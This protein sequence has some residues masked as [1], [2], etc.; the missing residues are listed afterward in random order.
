MFANGRRE[1]NLHNAEKWSRPTSIKVSKIDKSTRMHALNRFLDKQT[2]K[3]S[4]RKEDMMRQ[5]RTHMH[6]GELF[7]S[8]LPKIISE[9]MSSQQDQHLRPDVERT[10]TLMMEERELSLKSNYDQIIQFSLKFDDIFLF[11]T[12]N[13]QKQNSTI[14]FSEIRR[15]FS[16]FDDFF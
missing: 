8:R 12:T 11:S 16:N 2:W 7:S 1:S 9:L 3:P 4:I 13:F 10:A 5:L 15:F 6:G 14:N